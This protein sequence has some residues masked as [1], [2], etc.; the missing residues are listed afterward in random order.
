MGLAA[1]KAF[2]EAGAAVVLAD[3]RK[4]A[5][6]SVA[7]ELSA[8]GHRV[9][10]IACDVTNEAQVQAMV[11]HTVAHFSKLDAA[12]N[13]AGIISQPSDT[14]SLGS[15]EW[16]R[17]MSVNLRGVW[18]CMKYELLQMSSQG[19]GA[20]VNNS[21]MGGLRGAAG[22]PAY[23]ASK[24]GLMGLT[25]TAALEYATKGIR[26]NAVCPGMIDTPMGDHLTGGNKEALQ[27]MTQIPP[28]KRFGTSQEVASA[29]LWLCSAG[30]GYV[31][32]HGLAVDGGVTA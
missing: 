26:I 2:A 32:G 13:N 20:I 5:V 1:A 19:S 22:L 6:R 18:L 8:A 17:V 31:T 10:P 15:D 11:E 3:T 4:E 23:A 9:L 30:A 29:V 14:S 28:M 27:A 16:E 21:S 7:D 25:K 24:H 12:F